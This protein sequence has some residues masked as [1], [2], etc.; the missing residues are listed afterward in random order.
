MPIQAQCPKCG[1]RLRVSEAMV[2]KKGKCPK[3]SAVF[4]LTPSKKNRWY[5]QTSDGR[6][7]GPLTRSE[8]TGLDPFCQLRREDWVDWKWAEDVLPELALAGEEKSTVADADALPAPSPPPPPA[9]TAPLE[10]DATPSLSLCPDCGKTVSIRTG[11]CP[12]CGCPAADVVQRGTPVATLADPAVNGGARKRN[13][14]VGG[15]AIASVLI[16]FSVV[17]PLWRMWRTVDE[18]VSQFDQVLKP[19]EKPPIE[20]ASGPPGRLSPDQARQYIEQASAE[21]A[22]R[23]DDEFRAAHDFSLAMGL[24]QL[25]EQYRSMQALAQPG[26]DAL[27]SL[28]ALLDADSAAARPE[29]Y[30]SQYGPFLAE[31]KAHVE[32]KVRVDRTD[33][34]AIWAA[35][36]EWERA[37]RAAF[38]KQLTE[39]LQLPL[40]P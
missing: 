28:D 12:H 5:V 36:A 17:W 26:D 18:T 34:E 32:K 30:E 27:D 21:N 29:S 38:E 7:R 1:R 3:C 23:L 35:A 8:L 39:R 2:G 13:L 31:C 33:R 24:E 4:Q 11:Q 10:D 6:Q 40:G 15:V 16:V 37:K 25:K 19:S 22:R 20:P 14:I 9:P